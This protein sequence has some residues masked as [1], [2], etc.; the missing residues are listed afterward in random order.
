MSG[1][2]IQRAICAALEAAFGPEQV[3]SEYSVANMM[4]KQTTAKDIRMFR[5]QRRKP[6]RRG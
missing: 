4:A 1:R 2:E 5:P 3:V 6:L